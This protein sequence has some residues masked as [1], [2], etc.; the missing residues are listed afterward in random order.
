MSVKKS[1]RLVSCLCVTW[2]RPQQ[3]R[4]SINCFLYQSYR[5]TE[6][7]VVFDSAD[8]QTREVL[9]EYSRENIRPV[10]VEGARQKSL[11]ELRNISVRHARGEYVCTWDDDDWYHSERLRVQLDSLLGF[12]FGGIVLS[13]LIMYD[14]VGKAAYLSLVRPW[15]NTLLVAREQLDTLD[16]PYP[17]VNKSEDEMLVR[18]LVTNGCMGFL[19]NPILYIYVYSGNNTWAID[20][21]QRFYDMSVL[22]P[23]AQTRVIS[24]IMEGGY[25]QFDA[26]S[27]LSEPDFQ[28][29]FDRLL[30]V[31]QN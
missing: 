13:S 11:G 4:R 3:L 28:A 23:P 20:H 25:S 7:V 8:A 6:L 17:H 14:Q 22:L 2:N 15:E 26:S 9:A 21:F 5:H 10:A 30:S 29:Y 12:G 1:G 31:G 27:R 16:G 18:Q 24:K 19:A